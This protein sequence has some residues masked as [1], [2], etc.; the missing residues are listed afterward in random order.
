M[1]NMDFNGFHVF[2]VAC[3]EHPVSCWGRVGMWWDVNVTCGLT[4]TPIWILL[5]LMPYNLLTHLILGCSWV[6]L[7]GKC[8]EQ[9]SKRGKR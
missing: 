5:R 7:L 6:R 1:E 8:K 9:T 3:G 4:C 2:V